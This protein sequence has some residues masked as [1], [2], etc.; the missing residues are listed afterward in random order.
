MELKD[1]QQRVLGALDSYPDE[2]TA[3]HA[4][5]VKIAKL[6]EADPDLDLDLPDFTE[7]A[8]GK[9]REAA[10]LPPVRAQIPFSP[11]TDG[12][13]PSVTFKVPTGGGKTWLA[14]NAI[15]SVLL[16]ADYG[17][18]LDRTTMEQRV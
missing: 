4:S 5:F 11:R 12:I 18:A 6:K 7:K 13:V 16:E 14:A 1:F 3:S 15:S 10:K 8:W 17:R 9:L 2:L